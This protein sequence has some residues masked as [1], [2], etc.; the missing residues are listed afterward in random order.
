[1]SYEVESGGEQGLEVGEVAVGGVGERGAHGADAVS[2]QPGRG[3]HQGH[4]VAGGA[5]AQFD[6]GDVE[7]AQQLVHGALVAVAQGGEEGVGDLGGEGVHGG[8]VGG[9]A[10][11][12]VGAG[13]DLGGG[14]AVEEQEVLGG[15]EGEALH[16]VEVAVA[17]L[18]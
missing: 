18:E 1:G 3:L 17:V 15:G 6:E 5:A 10:D 16:P 7:A 9:D 4:R 8:G 13:L 14:G 2:A 12:G 11:G